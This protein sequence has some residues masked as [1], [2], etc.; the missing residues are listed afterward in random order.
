MYLIEWSDGR[1]IVGDW[2][3]IRRHPKYFVATVS[4]WVAGLGWVVC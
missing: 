4:E 2:N 1:E 3:A